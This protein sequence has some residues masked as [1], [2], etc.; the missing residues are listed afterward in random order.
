MDSKAFIVL[1]VCTVMISLIRVMAQRLECKWT[2][3]TEMQ[4]TFFM[5]NSL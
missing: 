3:D 5:N 1:Y 2:S 4:G